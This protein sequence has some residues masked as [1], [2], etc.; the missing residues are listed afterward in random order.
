MKNIKF[1]LAMG[2][3]FIE[4]GKVNQNLGEAIQMIKNAAKQDCKI[5]VLPECLDL[6]WTYPE[7]YKLA[8][9]IPGKY[10]DI[11]SHAA[12]ESHIYIVAGLTE[13]AENQIYNAA[14]LI[15]SDGKI[16]LKHRKINVLTIAQDI[17]SIGDSLSVIKTP[18]G[19][20]GI[21]ICADNFFNSLALGHSLARM[22]AQILL[23]PSAWVVEANYD[24]N[25]NPY[26]EMWKKPYTT[27][28]KL[29][30]IT[31]IGVSGVGWINTGVLKGHKYI[32][33]SL[34]IGPGGNILAQGPYGESAKDLIIVE[35]KIIQ[36]NI[37]GTAIAES[38][39]N[40]GYEGP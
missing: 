34:A 31:V 13:K 15:S 10:S 12:Q 11:L 1:K 8:Q 27:L 33:C 26:G 22:G 37:R 23:S 4:G 17:Y 16:L 5:I 9:P 21:D 3:M 19:T 36:N 32:G 18:L 6:G 40:K 29:Y 38:L 39:K 14:V 28:A 30:D 2:Q 25:K 24:N 7:A 20:I 35:V